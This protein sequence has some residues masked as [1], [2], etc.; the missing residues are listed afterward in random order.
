MEEH[1]E[2]PVILTRSFPLGEF[3]LPVCST[4]GSARLKNLVPS[5]KTY[6][7]TQEGFHLTQC[8]G[9]PLVVQGSHARRS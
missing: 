5:G 9:Y 1:L 7:V 6:Q 8:H 3:L 2:H 4:L